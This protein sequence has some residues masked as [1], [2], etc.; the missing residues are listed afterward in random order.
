MQKDIASIRRD[1]QMASLEEGAT[2]AHPMDQFSHWWE[3]AI[4]SNIDEVNAFVLSTIDDNSAPASRVL[5][6]K[7]Y[8]PEG[9]V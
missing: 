3:D 4:A 6:L 7:G 1:Y 9:F 5:L 2:S 8:T